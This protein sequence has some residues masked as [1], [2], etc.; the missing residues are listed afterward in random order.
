MARQLTARRPA[1]PC[2]LRTLSEIADLGRPATHCPIS[3]PVQHAHSGVRGAR[4]ATGHRDG[5]ALAWKEAARRQRSAAQKFFWG[6][7]RP[8]AGR[9]PGHSAPFRRPPSKGQTVL[10]P[11]AHG[12]RPVSGQAALVVQ[13]DE[14]KQ[15][16]VWTEQW[17]RSL[18]A[19]D[20]AS[21]RDSTEIARA[22]WG[23]QKGRKRVGEGRGSRFLSVCKCVRE[24]RRKKRLAVQA[25]FP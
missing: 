24:K 8:R 11:A 19:H 25:L 4:I 15:K 22:L 6:T 21:R 5:R 20:Q 10:S 7:A 2:L 18:R 3:P 23:A 1:P 17:A 14:P 12:V 9:A 13:R 16:K